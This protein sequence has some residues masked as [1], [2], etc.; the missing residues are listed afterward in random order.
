MSTWYNKAN[1]KKFSEVQVNV[2]NKHEK[3]L[4]NAQR[5]QILVETE[6]FLARCLIGCQLKG[7]YMNKNQLKAKALDIHRKLVDMGIYDK[8]GERA[9][10]TIYSV[11]RRSNV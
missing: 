8:N 11:C 3:S 1:T 7:I 2:F 10:D 6:I 5:P 4:N 9:P